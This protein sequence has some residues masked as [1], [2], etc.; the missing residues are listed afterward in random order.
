MNNDFFEKIKY[1]QYLSTLDYNGSNKLY[2]CGSPP[3]ILTRNYFDRKV[4][5]VSEDYFPIFFLD[6][7]I[8][9]DERDNR[10]VLFYNLIIRKDS[11]LEDIIACCNNI[12]I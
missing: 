8:K 11:C 2:I 5:L 12:K 6:D 10:V 9:H 3:A 7:I 1:F 4:S